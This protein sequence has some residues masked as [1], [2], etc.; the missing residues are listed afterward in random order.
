[1]NKQLS[2]LGDELITAQNELEREGITRT[3]RRTIQR[4]IAAIEEDIKRLTTEQEIA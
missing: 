2:D 3:A 4:A 1:M